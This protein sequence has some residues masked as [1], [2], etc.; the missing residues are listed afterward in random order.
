MSVD[1]VVP[2]HNAPELVRRSLESVLAHVGHRLSELV[3]VD[4]ASDAP[5]VALLASLADPKLHVVR[6]E[7]NLGYGGSVNLPKTRTS[8]SRQSSSAVPQSS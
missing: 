6:S 3:V 2:V 7:R 5:T 1:A 4:D 8:A